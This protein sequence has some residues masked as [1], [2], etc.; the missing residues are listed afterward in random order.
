MPRANRLG[1]RGP[2]K[3]WPFRPG[4]SEAATSSPWS[5]S[6]RHPVT[7]VS[8][9]SH[10]ATVVV[11]LR[12]PPPL[13]TARL[14]HA[15]VSAERHRSLSSTPPPHLRAVESTMPVSHC[16]H[17]RVLGLSLP[18]SLRSH[19]GRRR[20]RFTT[21]H[22]ACPRP[23]RLDVAGED[24]PLV[25]CRRI[26]VHVLESH[27]RAK[28]HRRP[29]SRAGAALCH[30]L[31]ARANAACERAQHAG[32]GM[33]CRSARPRR[34]PVQPGPSGPCTTLCSKPRGHCASRLRAK[35]SPWP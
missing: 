25:P 30:R 34:C 14:P 35:A 17:R 8:P 4:R 10:H 33:G 15:Q 6:P 13:L 3:A 12:R 1:C 23:R 16:L 21:P 22:L 31:R 26:T 2:L 29:R 11:T 18:H 7:T 24:F 19:V 20:R 5:A 9:L 32:R 28:G 27:R